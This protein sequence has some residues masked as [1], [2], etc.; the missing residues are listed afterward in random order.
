MPQKKNPYALSYIRGLVNSLSGRFSEF[1]NMG[2]EVSGFPDSRIF[3][4]SALP[5]DIEKATSAINLLREIISEIK[6]KEENF[7][8]MLKNSSSFST[9]LTDLV[10]VKLKLDY[11]T[12][13]E[14][15]KNYIKIHNKYDYESFKQ[16][17]KKQSFKYEVLTKQDFLKAT[18]PMLII[19]TRSELKNNKKEIKNKKS[20]FI[21]KKQINRLNEK[22]QSS[23][24]NNLLSAIKRLMIYK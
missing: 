14:L 15:V 9:D 23:I 7:I 12:S 22:K 1:L 17:L 4:Y 13:Y 2:K 5:Q 20:F 11:K 18:D 8:K 24:N 10:M 21:K 3:I 16:F 6:F 19:K